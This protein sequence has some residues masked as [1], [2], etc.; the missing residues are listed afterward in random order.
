MKYFYFILIILIG[1]TSSAQDPRLFETTWYLQNVIV[2]GQNNFPPSNEEVPYVP[3]YIAP[4]YLE[5][6]VCDTGDGAIEFSLIDSSFLFTLGMAVTLGNC[7][8]SD[9]YPFQVIYFEDFF[10]AG[11]I[12]VED[13]F[14]Y[15]VTE[16]GDDML[17]LTL[18]S[19][20]GDQAIYGNAILATDDYRDTQFF[21]YPNPTSGILNIEGASPINKVVIYDLLGRSVFE[22]L[23]TSE[24][25]QID[26]NNLKA[27][28]YLASITSEGKRIVRKIVKE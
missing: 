27:G 12:T 2:D 23:P 3:L 9:N 25:V 11:Y 16:T 24:K 18:T 28:V 14:Q 8:I 20:R 19:P 10:D 21:L 4:D 15:E 13:I 26:M 1:Y 22:T 17:E 6:S 7:Y 5:T